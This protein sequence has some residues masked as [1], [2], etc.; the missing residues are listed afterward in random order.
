M[1][2][3]PVKRFARFALIGAL[4]FAVDSLCFA[5]LWQGLG[6][7][8]QLARVVAFVAAAS[9]TWLGNRWLTFADRP[10]QPCWHQWRRALASALV[11]AVPNLGVFQLLLMLL[12][13][14]GMAPYVALVG[15]ILA[16][17]GVNY[18]ASQTWV[19]A[20]ADTPSR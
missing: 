3:G 2:G 7:P 1:R 11:A 5:L 19:F 9:T 16:G 18:F 12:G 14:H 4:G 6:W 10:S 20:P 15:G 8:L 13:H 17:M